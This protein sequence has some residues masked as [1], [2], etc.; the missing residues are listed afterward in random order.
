MNQKNGE[1][2]N[3]FNNDYNNKKQNEENQKIYNNERCQMKL[4]LRKKKLNEIILDKRKL[5]IKNMENENINFGKLIFLNDSI[6]NLISKIEIKYKEEQ[7]VIEI[8]SKISYII[9]QKYKNYKEKII[10]NIYNFTSEDLINV[11]LAEKLCNLTQIYMNIP[12]AILYIS[13]ILLFSCL[14]INK[15]DIN[16]TN[17]FF[18]EKENFNKSGYFIS[19]NKYIDIYNKILELYLNKN[20]D[21]TS[22]MVLFI[23]SIVNEQKTNQKSLYTSGTFKYILE[24]VNMTNDSKNLLNKKIWCLSKFSTHL[25]YD[26]NLEISLKIQKIYLEIFLNQEKYELFRDI[27]EKEYDENNFFFNFMKLIENTACCTENIFVEN[28]IKS[29]IL[30]F[31][32]DNS[33]N[34]NPKIIETI[35]DILMD[36]TYVN[37]ALGKRLINIGVIRY[38]KSIITDKSFPAD[39]RQ[40]SIVPINNLF[41]EP[42]LWKFILFDNKVLEM[43]YS[44]LNDPD[45]KSGILMEILSGLNQML[46]YY[47]NEEEE[48]KLNIIL[49]KYFIIQLICKAIKQIIDTNKIDKIMN[50]CFNYFCC[51]I[52]YL[53]ANYNDD[54]LIKKVITRFQNSGG[55]EIF[56]LIIHIYSN[57]NY[58]DIKSDDNNKENTLTMI[59]IIKDKIKDL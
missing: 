36:I 5:G 17:L 28:L 32:M 45:I 30:E 44:L 33:F 16:D 31:L 6:T 48:D 7:K 47:K 58:E 11:N 2:N 53:L 10:S 43:F 22:N 3:I 12:Q 56:D 59:N 46:Y 38:L 50:L 54:N 13:R 14:I 4:S 8:L 39:L 21:I 26:C 35:I 27:N 15:D 57:I 40:A 24:S 37:S 1:I 52:L 23:G 29:N 49:D 18:D 20:Y 42:N 41:A 9:E 25:I 51:F 55:E 34:K 19:S